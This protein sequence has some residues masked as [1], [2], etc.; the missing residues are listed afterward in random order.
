MIEMTANLKKA[1]MIGIACCGVTLA[2]VTLVGMRTDSKP[3]V[4]APVTEISPLFVTQVPVIET[5]SEVPAAKV[6]TEEEKYLADW[7]P[8]RTPAAMVDWLE[9]EVYAN[10]FLRRCEKDWLP[11][12]C[13]QFRWE[14]KARGF[15][16]G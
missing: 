16:I 7:S 8:A 6:Q 2:G 12:T 5:P 3:Q 9:N 4:A 13:E 15:E 11:S 10:V 1:A 14:M